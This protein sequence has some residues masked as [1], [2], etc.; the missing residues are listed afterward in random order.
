MESY[1]EGFRFRD[2]FFPFVSANYKLTQANS[3]TTTQAQTGVHGGGLTWNS[4]AATIHHGGIMELGQGVGS[5]ILLAGRTVYMSIVLNMTTI[6]SFPKM[7]FGLGT[8]CVATATNDIATGSGT[9]ATDNAVGFLAQG[10]DG[11]LDFVSRVSDVETDANLDAHTLVDGDD[12]KLEFVI[13]GLKNAIPFV[14]GVRLDTLAI[15]GADLPTALMAPKIWFT[16]GG[17][18]QSIMKINCWEIEVNDAETVI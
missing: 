9:I 15:P 5:I 4:G 3:A 17:S 16:N 10:T 2:K 12:V 1:S 8:T 6:S 18:V 13:N 14:N 7:F 11:H